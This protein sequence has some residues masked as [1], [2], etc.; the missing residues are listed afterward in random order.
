[1]TCSKIEGRG[2]LVLLEAEDGRVR[3]QLRSTAPVD[4]SFEIGRFEVPWKVLAQVIR[5]AALSF[6]SP[7]GFVVMRRCGQIVEVCYGNDLANEYGLAVLT[8]EEYRT[9][10]NGLRTPKATKPFKFVASD[11]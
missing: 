11:S 3:G 9:L 1:M 8:V 6:S 10:M 2:I 4:S 5:H 7:F